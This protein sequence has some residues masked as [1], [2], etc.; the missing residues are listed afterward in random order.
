MKKGQMMGQPFMVIFIII[1]IALL[2]FF[3]IRVVRDL[4]IFGERTLVETFYSDLNEEFS[5]INDLDTGSRISLEKINPPNKMDEICFIDFNENLNLDGVEEEKSIRLQ[6]VWEN[7]DNNLIFIP[8]DGVYD[9][10]ELKDFKV[11]ENPLCEDLS[12]NSLDLGLENKGTY[13]LV[14]YLN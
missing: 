1:V 6:I 4:N 7:K 11:G 9:Y 10:R 14:S 3:G 5:S 12:D 8:E 13:I 2:L